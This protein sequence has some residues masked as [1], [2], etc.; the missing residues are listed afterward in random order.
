MRNHH[1]LGHACGATSVAYGT[2]IFW[3]W[4]CWFEGAR[5]FRAALQRTVIWAVSEQVN[6]FCCQESDQ[7][8]SLGLGLLEQRCSHGFVH[9]ND[10]CQGGDL[11]AVAKQIRD[12]DGQGVAQGDKGYLVHGRNCHRHVCLSAYM[13][14]G[15][16]AQGIVEGHIDIRIVVA[17]KLCNH[18]A[19]LWESHVNRQDTHSGRLMEYSPILEFFGRPRD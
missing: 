9:G 6:L 7:I 16:L 15:L 11:I 17:C 13:H 1:A 3:G 19:R 5:G 2:E 4:R 10:R 8:D 14:D 12:L 18:L